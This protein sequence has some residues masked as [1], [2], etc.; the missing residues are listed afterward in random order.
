MAGLTLIDPAKLS[1]WGTVAYTAAVSGISAWT[2]WDD[3]AFDSDT[4]EI[5]SH[6]RAGFAFGAGALAV[7]VARPAA[8]LDKALIAWMNRHRVPAPRALLAGATLACSLV[9]YLI[10]STQR[11]KPEPPH[12]PPTPGPLDE[13][14]RS[15]AQKI[16]AVTNDWGAP[17]LREQLAT[18]RGLIV[19]HGWP[20]DAWVDIA[21]SAP[22]TISNYYV[23]PYYGRYEVDGRTVWVAVHI[24]DGELTCIE[25]TIDA[26]GGEVP[27]PWPTP[28]E[29][30]VEAATVS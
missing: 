13:N 5:C 14:A 27:L 25:R 10:Q 3:P 7:A 17:A 23:F 4:G 30:T 8:K 28:D 1:R 12:Q 19:P 21:E 11:P 24:C 2:V 15:I 22:R 9:S 18:A 20:W 26:L 6:G 29:V 16:L